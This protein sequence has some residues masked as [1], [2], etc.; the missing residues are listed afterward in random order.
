MIVISVMVLVGTGL[1][2]FFL[3]NSSDT[4]GDILDKNN[5][6]GD[7]EV[8]QIESIVFKNT[9][10]VPKNVISSW[11]AGV[12]QNGSIM[13][14]ALDTNNNGAYELY[15]GQKGKVVLGDNTTI[16]MFKSSSF[17]ESELKK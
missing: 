14:Y 16:N 5:M 13:A 6:Y 3:S 1:L 9:N 2:Y 15:I 11:D 12:K 8:D 17:S 4:N 7:L 10:N